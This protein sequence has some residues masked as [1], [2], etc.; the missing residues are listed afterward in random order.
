[1]GSAMWNRRDG[2]PWLFPEINRSQKQVFVIQM[3]FVLFGIW[4]VWGVKGPLWGSFC[5]VLAGLVWC[6]MI[7]HMIEHSRAVQISAD[8]QAKLAQNRALFT[9]R[10]NDLTGGRLLD[11]RAMHPSEDGPPLRAED[12]GAKTPPYGLPVVPPDDDE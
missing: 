5:L 11:R 8:T 4:V 10:E 2:E 7:H 9:A 6:G 12:Y 1:M 3:L